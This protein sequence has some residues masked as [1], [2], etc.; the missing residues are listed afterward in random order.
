MRECF[1]IFMT[2][3]ETAMPDPQQNPN[4]ETSTSAS[5]LSPPE[6]ATLIATPAPLRG[7][8]AVFVSSGGLSPGWGIFLYL[9]M[10]VI[11]FLILSNLLRLIPSRGAGFL[12]Q[13]MFIQAV[14]V[15]SCL[16]PAFVMTRI[17]KRPFCL[18]GLPIRQARVR[19]FCIGLL[20][21]ILALSAL[22]LL[23]RGVG[24]FSYGSVILHGLRIWKF[25]LFW[26]VFFFLVGIFEEF[27]FRGYTQFTLSE[28]IGFWPAAF[29]W[30][31]VFGSLHLIGNVGET[32][33]GSLCAAMIGLFFCFTLRRTGNLWF[34]VG[35]HASWDW[36][37]SYLYSVPDS[38]GTVPGHL[39]NSSFH[40][41]RWLTGGSV[42]PEGSVLVF[43][44]IGA[45]WVV[46][47]RMYPGLRVAGRTDEPAPN[48]TAT[49]YH[50]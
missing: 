49:V 25:A 15:I 5:E 6:A 12:W 33:L 27:T 32:W 23:L 4:P 29:V 39:L 38:G 8:P 45:A 34:A 31:L 1:T 10:G 42:G 13:Q 41:S 43:V 40:G 22:M 21:G 24:V 48:Q 28:A 11:L 19:L 36:G 7:M 47:D 14:L 30:A 17:E 35:M 2:G 16:V 50:E 26:G 20:W 37:E 44:V 9:G 3:M 46:F 18:Y